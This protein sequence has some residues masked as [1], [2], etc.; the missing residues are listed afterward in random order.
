MVH[1]SYKVIILP[2]IQIYLVLCLG[3][4]QLPMLQNIREQNLIRE[5]NLKKE[6][7]TKSLIADIII[8]NPDII[9]YVFQRKE[10]GF[11]VRL[12]WIDFLSNCVTQGLV[13]TLGN[14]IFSIY[15]QA[16]VT[17]ICGLPCRLH[18]A[19]HEKLQVLCLEKKWFS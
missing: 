15:K 19:M 10:H 11:R 4:F 16:I 7:H 3:D 9:Y 5:W 2:I 6:A 17:L 1:E 14:S 18:R 13:L 8:M 12:A